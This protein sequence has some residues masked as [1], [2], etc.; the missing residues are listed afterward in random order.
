MKF[1]H[2]NWLP[3]VDR[4]RTLVVAPSA[5]KATA[6]TLIPRLPLPKSRS[7]SEFLAIAQDNV[8]L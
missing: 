8:I 6:G 3:V 1:L 2:G 5:I 7:F 4:F